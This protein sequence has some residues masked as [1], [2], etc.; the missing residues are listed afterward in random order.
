MGIRRKKRKPYHGENGY[1]EFMERFEGYNCWLCDSVYSGGVS[2]LDRRITIDHIAGRNSKNA[3]ARTNLGLYCWR[4]HR[5]RIPSMSMQD[6]VLLK[7]KHDPE[8]FDEVKFLEI[9]RCK[10]GRID[11]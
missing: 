4:C 5:D 2:Y 1:E 11:F 8:G 3:N 7:I 10:G 6:K 9:R